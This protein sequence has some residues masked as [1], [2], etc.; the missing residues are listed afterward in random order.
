MTSIEEKKETNE[1][2]Q[3]CQNLVD[4]FGEEKS[5]YDLEPILEQRESYVTE[6]LLLYVFLNRKSGFNEMIKCVMEFS[7]GL[8]ME[9]ACEL[10]K[11]V[12]YGTITIYPSELKRAGIPLPY[13][14]Y[15]TTLNSK[16]D[17]SLESIVRFWSSKFTFYKKEEY[18]VNLLYDEIISLFLSHFSMFMAH[19]HETFKA[20]TLLKMK[21]PEYFYYLDCTLNSRYHTFR[22]IVKELKMYIPNDICTIV[23]K[24]AL[25]NDLFTNIYKLICE[26]LEKMIKEVLGIPNP[27]IN[28]DHIRESLIDFNQYLIQKYFEYRMVKYNEKLLFGFFDFKEVYLN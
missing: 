22:Q 21:L 15:S 28:D 1:F 6:D 24:Q 18:P 13:Y 11:S 17:Y 12:S 9:D 19:K 2:K 8:S 4:E 7:P 5:F 27:N 25:R 14:K 20:D 10:V 26:A 3:L 23:E 16:K